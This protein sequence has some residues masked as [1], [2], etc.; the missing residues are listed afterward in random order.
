[1][2]STVQKL[3]T[4]S[5]F[6]GAAEKNSEHTRARPRFSHAEARKAESV[7]TVKCTWIATVVSIPHDKQTT[8]KNRRIFGF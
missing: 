4:N 5:D 7:R 3:S 8:A 6:V 2:R 1:M